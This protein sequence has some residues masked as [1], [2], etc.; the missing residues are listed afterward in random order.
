[1]YKRQQIVDK[2][3]KHEHFNIAITPEAT[4]KRNPDWKKGFYFIALKANVP[5]VLAYIDYKEKSIGLKKTFIPTGDF[6]KDMIKIKQF[7]KNY[8]AKYPDLFAIE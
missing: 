4:R 2:F 1:M 5:I 8:H 3:N 7:Y 6:E